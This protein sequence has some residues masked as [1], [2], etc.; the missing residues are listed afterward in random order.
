MRR[1]VFFKSESSFL[2]FFSSVSCFLTIFS[3][4]LKKVFFLIFTYDD[5]YCFPSC[6]QR[7]RLS[8]SLLLLALNCCKCVCE[9]VVFQNILRSYIIEQIGIIV[10]SFSPPLCTT[11]QANNKQTLSLSCLDT[12]FK[13]YFIFFFLTG[14]IQ[15]DI[16]MYIY[17][18]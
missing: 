17:R 7:S 16:F 9:C 2:I 18:F 10:E 15:T 8:K 13:I 12:L 5:R 6:S 14:N 1:I 3:F 11:K 4:S